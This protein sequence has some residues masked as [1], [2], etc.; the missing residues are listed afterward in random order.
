MEDSK[1]I[2]GQRSAACLLAGVIVLAA[3]PLAAQ[4]PPAPP[5]K[6]APVRPGSAADSLQ[7]RIQAVTAQLAAVR[8]ELAA[9]RQQ[10]LAKLQDRPRATQ[11]RAG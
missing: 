7:A 1:A 6:S 4:M 3:A 8:Q 5:V 2:L 10:E 9:A 11:K